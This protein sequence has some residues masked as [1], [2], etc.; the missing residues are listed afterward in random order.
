[1]ALL[2]N[3]SCDAPSDRLFELSDRRF[4]LIH[5][6]EVAPLMVGHG[7]I[8]AQR[9]L[10]EFIG[11]L[12]I[13]SVTIKPVVIWRRSENVEIHSY[14]RI[15]TSHCVVADQIRD[16]QY[17]GAKLMMYA[18]EYLFVTESLKERLREAEFSYLSFSEGLSNFAGDSANTE[19]LK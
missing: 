8:L 16:G 1:M 10:A 18:N 12:G 14:R 13:D 5:G 2:Y 9:R 11:T 7:Y 6:G 19:S 4:Q 15:M 17:G 3:V